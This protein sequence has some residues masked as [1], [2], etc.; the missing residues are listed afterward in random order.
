LIKIEEAYTSIFNAIGQIDPFK[1]ETR[2]SNILV[3]SGINEA[4]Y[5]YVIS[6]E[7]IE[8]TT[9]EKSISFFEMDSFVWLIKADNLVLNKKLKKRGFRI[10]FITRGFVKAL[11]E[12]YDHKGKPESFSKIEVERIES[13]NDLEAWVK[14]CASVYKYNSENLYKFLYPLFMSP[15]FS[16]FYIGKYEKELVTTCLVLRKDTHAV[17]L[18]VTT[19]AP[20][21]KRGI[22]KKV[23]LKAME[24]AYRQGVKSIFLDTFIWGVPLF[25][26][27]NFKEVSGF[28]IFSYQSGAKRNKDFYV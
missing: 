15:D 8:G 3:K 18:F 10:N 11:E 16:S 24:D 5:N 17:L 4:P 9:I 26:S 2:G 19:K 25:Q 27:L 6:S 14:S 1:C 20:Y 21:R 13:T 23:I 28:N 7:N 22:A 12:I